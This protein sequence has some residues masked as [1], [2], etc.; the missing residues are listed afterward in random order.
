MQC[1]DGFLNRRNP[2]MSRSFGRNRPNSKMIPDFDSRWLVAVS[3]DYETWQPIPDG[4]TIDWES[5]VFLPAEQLMRIFERRQAAVTFFAEMGEYIWL[6]QNRPEIAGRMAAQLEDAV[7][8]GHDVQLHL[9]P[10]WLPELG[11]EC[12]NG[13]WYWDWSFRRLHDYPGDT[14]ALI[15]KCKEKLESIGRRA[16]PHYAVTCFRAGGYS[17]QPFNRIYDALAETGIFCDSSVYAGGVDRERKYDYSLAWSDHQPYFANRFDPQFKAP[18][19]EQSV[20]ELPIFAWAR[21]RRWCLDGDAAGQVA[22]QFFKYRSRQYGSALSAFGGRLGPAMRR[23]VSSPHRCPSRLVPRSLAY[24]LARFGPEVRLEGQYF[25]MIGHTK[26]ILDLVP[27]DHALGRLQAGGCQVKS[28]SSMA[29]DAQRELLEVQLKAERRLPQQTDLKHRASVR[30]VRNTP[31]S[32]PLVAKVPLDRGR[33]LEIRHDFS[34]LPSSLPKLYP[35][36]KIEYALLSALDEE[37]LHGASDLFDCIYADN[38]LQYASDVDQVLARAYQALTLGGVLLATVPCDTRNSLLVNDDHLWKAAPHEI[39]LRLGAAGFVNVCVEELNT[40]R[41][42]SWKPHT[43]SSRRLAYAIAW[44]RSRPA[45][46]IDRVK[47]AMNWV[48]HRLEPGK[49]ANCGVDTSRI[50]AKGCGLC[51]EYATVLGRLL[52]RE[53]YKVVWCSMLAEGHPRG[54]GPTRRD[55]HEVLLVDLDG[56]QV[57]V[58]AMANT[59]HPYS[60]VELLRNPELAQEK[61]LPD[62][63]YKVYSFCFYDTSEWY[64]RV[65]RYQL[66]NDIATSAYFVRWRNN[67]FIKQKQVNAPATVSD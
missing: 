65:V 13:N 38:S 53:G 61:S 56:Y 34:Q 11:A 54:R 32:G 30:V 4:R 12:R 35:W 29:R 62:E 3:I 8:R 47:E 60:L 40:T 22:D 6:E 37:S 63:R 31:E 19:A 64:S 18:F 27:L 25:I 51:L 24:R 50:I 16:N 46:R 36:M 49:A 41:R 39:R 55:S 59:C 10:N 2:F 43:Y 5:D 45:S 17:A 52:Q 67:R 48:Y 66:R 23:L 44:K 7:R 28:L 57:V 15:A 58:D 9:H 1:Q 14:V 26:A 21:G 20:I 42:F 33:I